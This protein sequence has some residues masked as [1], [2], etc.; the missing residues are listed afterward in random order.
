MKTTLICLPV[1]LALALPS[2]GARAADPAAQV[3]S[4][5]EKLAAAESYAWKTLTQTGQSGSRAGQ[6]EGSATKAGLIHLSSIS[7]DP[8]AEAYLMNG[9]GAL[10][11]EGLWQTLGEAAQSTNTQAGAGRWVGR[12]LQSYKAPAAEAA[13]LAAKSTSLRRDNDAIAG[14][15]S[16]DAV[17]AIIS[18]WGVRV[19]DAEM[20]ISDARGL[21]KFWVRDGL[22]TK[23][24]YRVYAVLGLEGSRRTV[25]RTI[26]VELDQIGTAKVDLPEEARQKLG[27]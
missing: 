16:G 22:L 15:L 27:L 7:A 4:A 26:T 6:F 5:A 17:R 19:G 10:K 14:I 8:G 25:D 23:Y 20:Q 3:A 18:R 13:E 9:K 12:M 11:R 2:I 1:L 21:I 24:E